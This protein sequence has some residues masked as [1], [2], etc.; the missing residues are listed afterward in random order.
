MTVSTT[1]WIR[2]LP[3]RLINKIAAGEVIERPAAVVKELVENSLDADATTIGIHITGAGTG[4]IK[5][6]D[7]GCG[8]PEEQVEIAF[9]RH[10]TSK[11]AAI[12]DL[13]RIQSYGFRGEALPAIAS[14][15]RLRIVSR[16][17]DADVGTELR[18]EGGVV[19]AKR[20]VAANPGTV[21]EV[22][23]LFFNVPARRKFLKSAAA[24]SR[25]LARVVTALVLGRPDVSFT[26]VLNDRQL[27]ALPTGQTPDQRMRAVLGED[28]EYVA[29]DDSRTDVAVH[30]LVGTPQFAQRDR[31]GLYLFV[32]RRWVH[33][34]ALV[35]AV[36]MAFGELL[37]SGQFPVGALQIAVPPETLDVNIHPAK[38]EVRFAADR[39]VRDAVYY[40]VKEALRRETQ[41]EPGAPPNE[42][43]GTRLPLRDPWKDLYRPAGQPSVAAVDLQTGE[44]VAERSP[45]V[46][47][48]GSDR[49]V[50]RAES[51]PLTAADLDR[52][53]Y[54]GQVGGLYLIFDFDETLLLVDQHA[55]H[56]RVN[57]ETFLRQM[58][59]NAA[60]SQQLLLPV[61]V[62]LTADRFAVFAETQS[63]LTRAGIIAVPFGGTTVAIE[64][65][66]SQLSRRSPE[67]ILTIVLDDLAAD[68]PTGAHLIKRIAES[69]A[70]RASVM[71]GD[72]MTR[73]EANGLLAALIACETG[74]VCPH[75][76][77]TYLRLSRAELD[78]RFGRT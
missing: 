9:A 3:P 60:V 69:L 18:I 41:P 32:N 51:F 20:P 29:L 45:S 52:L 1:P 48:T 26:F 65:I 25:Q 63:D 2:P 59:N 4:M 37:P 14:V 35:Q 21:I 39:A 19:E 13:D 49:P 55:A 8:I 10:A 50:G 22:G 38:T 17:A 67:T 30:G 34:V 71:A 36:R 47:S 53:Q 77:P 76:R 43:V 7:D 16:P 57:Y 44:I 56:E 54:L 72:R 70:C 64:A 40:S 68:R 61:T 6:V 62:D 11:I 27:F 31:T 74:A 66:P 58:N 78:R 28:R 23:D 33:S 73:E 42:S 15:S 75:G 12:D 24:E 46:A 5:V